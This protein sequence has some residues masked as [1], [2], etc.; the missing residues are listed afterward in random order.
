MPET[1]HLRSYEVRVVGARREHFRDLYHAALRQPL[2][3]LILRIVFLFLALNVVFA[4]VYVECGGIANAR[5]GSLA[6][7][8]FFSVQTMGTI[9]Y[10]AMYPVS[11]LANTLVV[12]EAVIGLLVTAVATGLVFAKFSQPL[13]RI[14]FTRNAVITLMDGVPTLMFRLGNERGNIIAEAQVRVVLIR[15]TVSVEGMKLY[16]MADL[17]LV[18]DRSPALQRS[19]TV[20]HVLGPGSPLEGA[21]PESIARDEVELM[22]TVSGTDDTSLQPV[23]ARR[24][25]EARDIVWGARYADVLSE[26]PDGNLVLDVRRFHDLEPTAP[27]DAFP[28]PRP[29]AS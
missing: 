23:H 28:Y 17:P 7:A 11:G 29:S 13:G 18:R 9:G 25:Y 27:T 5:P 10:G 22:V 3:A 2:W 19:W 26:L 1:V 16:R 21:T 12:M 15:T 8:F 4:A 14:A 20:L 24:Q 6:D